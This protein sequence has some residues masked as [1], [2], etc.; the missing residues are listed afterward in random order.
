MANELVVFQGKA[1][2]V[3][4][5]SRVASTNYGWCL[6]G[7]PEGIALISKEVVPP[8]GRLSMTTERFWFGAVSSTQQKEEIEFTLIRLANMTASEQKHTVLVTVVPSDSDEFVGYCENNDPA[9]RSLRD[10]GAPDEAVLKYGYPC[11]EDVAAFKYGYPC[12]EDDAAFKYGYPCGVNDVSLKYGYACGANEAVLKYG[13]PCGVQDV[14]YKYGYPCGV[15]DVSLKY[16]YACGANEAG[17]KYGYACGVQDVAYKYG[18]PCGVNDAG[19]K[20]GYAC[21]ADDAVLKY[22]YPCQGVA[23]KYG[24][25]CADEEEEPGKKGSGAPLVSLMYGFPLKKTAPEGEPATE[26]P[27]ASKPVKA[28]KEA[29]TAKKKK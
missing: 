15:N 28:T 22:G 13:Y 2:S 29:K 7:L 14:A 17:L 3:E 23:V 20:Y 16:G 10:A 11:G 1:F 26:A 8:S 9:V 5:Q 19:L 12:G 27:E 21:G 4:L 6:T 25:P 24:I 18:Y